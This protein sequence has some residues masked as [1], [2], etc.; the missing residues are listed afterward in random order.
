M[1]E[2]KNEIS[3][4]EIHTKSTLP[5]DEPKEEKESSSEKGEHDSSAP[6]LRVFVPNRDGLIVETSENNTIAQ[7]DITYPELSAQ[8]TLSK[9]DEKAKNMWN[10]VYDFSPEVGAKKHWTLKNTPPKMLRLV[11][12][13]EGWHGGTVDAV[14]ANDTAAINAALAK[15]KAVDVTDGAGGGSGE[16]EEYL[17]DYNNVYPHPM[18]LSM[19]LDACSHI[20]KICRVLEQPKRPDKHVRLPLWQRSWRWPRQHPQRQRQR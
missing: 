4:L 2:T 11:P 7:W 19:F 18:L 20:C 8:F 5:V 6:N 9:I 1:G 3:H 15:T 16:V 17:D 14:D 12:H 10:T 13:P